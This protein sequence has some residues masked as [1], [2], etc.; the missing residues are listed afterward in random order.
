MEVAVGE[1]KFIKNNGF[2]GEVYFLQWKQPS[3]LNLSKFELWSVL[4]IELVKNKNMSKVLISFLG[5]GPVNEDRQYKTAD[6]TFS[7]GEK[8][9]TSFVAAAIKQYKQ[10][11]KLILIGTVKSMW[12]EVYRTFAENDINDE[13]YFQLAEHCQNSDHKS[14]LILPN[15]EK[16]EDAI[17]NNSKIILIKYGL[18]E[19]EISY[20]Q[21][22]I[23]NIESFLEKGD[24][25]YVDITH[26][27]RSLPLFLLNTL[28]YLQNV[29]SKKVIIC[30]ILYGMLDITRDLHYTPVVSLKKV[31]ET[32]EWISGAYSLKEF[33]NAYKIADLLGK[34]YKSA[35]QILIR[36]SDAK[37]LNYFGALESLVQE[38]QLLRGENELPHVAKMIVDPIIEDFIKQMKPTNTHHMFQYKLAQWH[39]EKMNYSSAYI[40]LTESIISFA[41][42]LNGL[43]PDNKEQRENAKKHI[44]DKP[45]LSDLKPVYTKINSV[46]KQL[47]HNVRGAKNIQTMI[48]NLESGLKEYYK[49]ISSHKL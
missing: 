36:F 1:V 35:S 6:Y 29:S 49:I 27:F 30:D 44:F 18:N 48:A 28:I 37:N 15:K 20:N 11:D 41:C 22:V 25:L 40:C 4:A 21:E 12:E 16:I 2:D 43:Q 45:E 9:T 42:Y 47:A 10:I 32:N 8:H 33:G 26:S 7:N 46:R 34:N 23:L 13:Y 39:F 14:E 31:I 3:K 38:I 5:T 24:E 17:G 19:D